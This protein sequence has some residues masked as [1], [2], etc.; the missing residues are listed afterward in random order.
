VPLPL[1][2]HPQP[3]PFTLSPHRYPALAPRQVLHRDLKPQ[4]IFLTRKNMVR[5][6]D[7]GISK[8]RPPEPQP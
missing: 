1:T 3:S 5:L 8:A 6:G 2:L 4:N 7:F